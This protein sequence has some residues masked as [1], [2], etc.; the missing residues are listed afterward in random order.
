[1]IRT[2]R[3]E[4]VRS[5]RDL[6][7]IPIR[8]ITLLVGENSAG[9]STVL[10]MIRA[11]WDVAFS[12]GEP[13]FNEPPF[14]LGGYEAIAHYHGGRG[15]RTHSFSIGAT[16]ALK[17]KEPIER[18]VSGR[19]SEQAGQPV[20][21]AF[22]VEQD[23]RSVTIEKT[24]AT[25]AH[26]KITRNLTVEID[27]DVTIGQGTPFVL[28]TAYAVRQ[29]ILKRIEENPKT[30]E[31]ITDPIGYLFELVPGW[32]PSFNARPIATAPVRSKPE[33]TYNPTREQQ[34]PEGSHVP[35]ELAALHAINNPEYEK[36]ADG[37]SEYGRQASL[38]SKLEVKR[39][40]KKAGEPFKLTVS[41]DR[42]PFNL[43]DVGYGVSQVLPIIVDTLRASA[44]QTFLLQQPEVHLHPK[45][46]A[47]LGSLLTA[48]AAQGKTFIVETHSD[49][50][51]DRIRME[52]RDKKGSNN[53]SHND[54]VILFFER[55]GGRSTVQPI[56]IDELGNL[57]QVPDNYRDFFLAEQHRLLGI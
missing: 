51:V 33:R 53:L 35:M 16:F 20:L 55:S 36:L 11:A 13:N 4:G 37:I 25:S 41:V 3:V 34:G 19:F 32:S 21:S 17:R 40:G 45:A 50:L 43:L 1:M 28:A 18:R 46:Q 24:S 9:K 30:R 27:E 42:Y 8:P 48:Q 54:V 44:G 15:K 26:V 31:K 14:D 57:L 52:V 47:A 5:F 12:M 29:K 23:G 39:F 22:T 38:F 7:D 56:Y 10:S 2:L 49:Y 6:T